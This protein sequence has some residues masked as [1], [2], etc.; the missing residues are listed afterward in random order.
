[1]KSSKKNKRKQDDRLGIKV[2]VESL[3]RKWG[4]F[5]CF[6]GGLGEGFSCDYYACIVFV[7]LGMWRMCLN[8]FIATCLRGNGLSGCCLC[9]VG[10]C[11]FMWMM[12]RCICACVCVERVKICCFMFFSRSC[13]VP[14]CFFMV[15]LG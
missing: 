15:L 12:L 14:T 1:M 2:F 4:R 11:V 7:F 10:A 13:I 6:F 8:G 5:G 9:Q 3:L